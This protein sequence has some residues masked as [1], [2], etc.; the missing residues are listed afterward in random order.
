MRNLFFKVFFLI[1][2]SAIGLFAIVAAFFHFLDDQDRIDTGYE[3]AYELA[4]EAVKTYEEKGLDALT[5]EFS[6]LLR[7]S[8]I[9]GFL[10]HGDGR[11]IGQRLPQFARDQ[12]THFP[13][14]IPE[15]VSPRGKRT[16]R[17]VTITT[18]DDQSYRFVMIAGHRIGRSWLFS[19]PNMRLLMP[20]LIIAVASL[21]ISVLITRPLG[22]L[23]TAAQNFSDGNLGARAPEK[24]TNRN[25]A[26]GELARE[27]NQMG[28]R[29]ETLIREH[30]RLLRDVSHELRSPLSRMQVAATLLEDKSDDN[31]ASRA[32]ITRI[33]SEILQLES[34]IAQL[35]SLTRL[36]SGTVELDKN[37]VDLADL[38]QG[39]AR[40]AIFE[41]TDKGKNVEVAVD[42]LVIKADADMLRSAF[43]NIVRNGL[44]YAHSTLNVELEYLSLSEPIARIRV[45]DN[46]P[47]VHER[48]LENI[49]E[50]F[51]RPDQSRSETTG[52]SGIGLAIAKG[53]VDAH[54]GHI[55]ARNATSGGLIVTIDLPAA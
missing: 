43:E 19:H 30:Q 46:G 13:Q 29:I 41:Y 15:A 4:D 21:L 18:D 49:F 20:L 28:S 25:D 24:L 54:G 47:G 11:S 33:Q 36:Q 55:S 12:I 40:D 1:L 37:E 14:T 16:L 27:Y 38:L 53:I 42:E 32:E 48:D 17:A 6:Q 35:L 31:P 44:R 45:T 26:F 23:K 50:P 34:M 51:Y 7:R 2:L 5:H 8:G 10:M 52:N 39:V 3:F 9:R 22:K